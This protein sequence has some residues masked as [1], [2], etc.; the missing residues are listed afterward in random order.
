MKSARNHIFRQAGRNRFAQWSKVPTFA[1]QKYL[2]SS[3]A[4]GRHGPAD[5]DHTFKPTHLTNDGFDFSEFNSMTQYFYLKIPS[6]Q[7][8]EW[9]VPHGTPYNVAGSIEDFPFAG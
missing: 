4:A 5:C 1:L 6:T 2:H 7:M 3:I 8:S 9:G